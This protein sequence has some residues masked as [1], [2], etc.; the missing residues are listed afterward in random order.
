MQRSVIKSVVVVVVVVVI[1][2]IV[3]IKFS[4]PTPC[5][6]RGGADV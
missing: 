2:I 5:G 6:H 4:L 3:I 1:I